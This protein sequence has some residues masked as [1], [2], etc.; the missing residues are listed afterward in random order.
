LWTSPTTAADLN[1]LVSLARGESLT[2]SMCINGPGEILA[3]I[4]GNSPCLLIPK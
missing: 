2:W 3:T 4:N 1:S